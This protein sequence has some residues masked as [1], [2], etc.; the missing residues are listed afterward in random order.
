MSS[1][2][3]VA[4]AAVDVLG[5]LAAIS[6]L[7][8]GI[9]ERGTRNAAPGSLEAEVRSRLPGRGQSEVVADT[10]RAQIAALGEREP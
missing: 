10:L 7:V 3:S 8:A 2:A 4:R 6:P 9:V 1:V 5:A